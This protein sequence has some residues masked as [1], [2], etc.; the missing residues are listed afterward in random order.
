MSDFHDRLRQRKAEILAEKLPPSEPVL[1]Q[2]DMLR[3]KVE[4]TMEDLA[5]AGTKILI[6]AC[7]FMGL[8]S[9]F[10]FKDWYGFVGSP[11]YAKWRERVERSK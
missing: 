7:I 4:R 8:F 10:I 6:G 5:S 1:T 2:E 9:Y 11:E 3:F